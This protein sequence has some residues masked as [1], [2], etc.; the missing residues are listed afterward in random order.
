MFTQFGTYWY[1]TWGVL[2][3]PGVDKGCSLKGKLQYWWCISFLVWIIFRF[4]H[5]WKLYH[6]VPYCPY[7]Y[8]VWHTIWTYVWE[9]LVQIWYGWLILFKLC[10][11]WV[12][13][14]WYINFWD[15]LSLDKPTQNHSWFPHTACIFSLLVPL[16]CC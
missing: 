4:N 11:G 6:I 5:N 3:D 16:F 15:T 12:C 2:N 8:N 14:I 1:F 10:F 13:Q 9:C 7:L